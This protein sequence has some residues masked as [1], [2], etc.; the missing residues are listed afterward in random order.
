MSLRRSWCRDSK[1][2]KN[3]R[4]QWI[5]IEL[6]WIAGPPKL[7]GKIAPAISGTGRT[8]VVDSH[9]QFFKNTCR[10]TIYC[11]KLRKV[12]SLFLKQYSILFY[13]VCRLWS[14]MVAVRGEIHHDQ[15]PH[16]P[17]YE[18]SDWCRVCLITI[19]IYSLNLD[20]PQFIIT[21]PIFNRR[22]RFWY[23][24]DP[25]IGTSLTIS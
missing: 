19:I 2:I 4:S 9:V 18:P 17:C 5:L 12:S 1:N 21:Q 3:R 25:C 6:Y 11:H 15:V 13:N 23:F 24:W 20:L 10:S 22:S 8:G 14:Y 16:E 7:Y